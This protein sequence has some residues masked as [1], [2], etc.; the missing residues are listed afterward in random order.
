MS[1][2]NPTY[3]MIP[4]RNNTTLTLPSRSNKSE[5][6]HEEPKMCR[7]VSLSE[8]VNN[9][10]NKVN[11]RQADGLGKKILTNKVSIHLRVFGLK[12]KD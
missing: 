3:I 7:W 4:T 11:M 5:F 8:Y 2:N 9:L 10:I 6:V 12:P 1:V